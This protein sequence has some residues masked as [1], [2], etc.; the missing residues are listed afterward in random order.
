MFKFLIEEDLPTDHLNTIPRDLP[1]DCT[2][3]PFVLPVYLLLLTQ[4]LPALDEEKV[5]R[6]R[7]LNN[8]MKDKGI[9]SLIDDF[10]EF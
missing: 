9:S 4:G 10:K 1:G 6:D 8:F 5:L 3:T 7:E 2:Y